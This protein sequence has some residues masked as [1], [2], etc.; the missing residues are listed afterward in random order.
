[1]IVIADTSG[2]IDQIMANIN[3]MYKAVDFLNDVALYSLCDS[4]IS[5]LLQPGKH[6]IRIPK[7]FVDEQRWCSYIPMGERCTVTTAGFKWDIG[8]YIILISI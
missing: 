1:M 4:S 3:T 8:K 5:W 6:L 7:L 2:R